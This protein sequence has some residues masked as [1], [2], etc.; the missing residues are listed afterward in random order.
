MA[1][2]QSTGSP[3]SPWRQGH[4][5][6]PSGLGS[7]PLLAQSQLLNPLE[8][9]QHCDAA[10]FAE[11]PPPGAGWADTGEEANDLFGLGLDPSYH[12]VDMDLQGVVDGFQPAGSNM[13]ARNLFHVNFIDAQPLPR[14]RNTVHYANDSRFLHLP[15]ASLPNSTSPDSAA[16]TSAAMAGQMSSSSAE[17]VTAGPSPQGDSDAEGDPA[18]KQATKRARNKLAARKCRQK[19][20][21][22]IAELEEALSSMTADR[23]GLRLQL[24]RKEAE[25]DA[26]REMFTRK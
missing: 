15:M 6:D 23:D 22:R 26:L 13:A 17:H 14:P 24:A 20:L 8:P 7:D 12:G 5:G 25:V 10:W 4:L 9:L 1:A 2:F 19:R 16:S 18:K 11:L 3:S 21:D